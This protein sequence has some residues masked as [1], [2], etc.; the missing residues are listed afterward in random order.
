MSSNETIAQLFFDQVQKRGQN[1]AVRFK[2]YKSGYQSLSWIDLSTLV[3]EIAFGL[4][5]LDVKHQQTVAIFSPTSYLWI[6][7][8]LAIISTGAISVPLY[9]NSSSDDLQHILNHCQANVIFVSAD[10]LPKLAGQLDKI[11]TCQKIIY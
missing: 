3:K 11:E 7:C 1:P 6:A 2:Q 5:A 9:P 8:D 10:L 4:A